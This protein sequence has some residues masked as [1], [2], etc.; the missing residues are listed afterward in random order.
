VLVFA[1]TEQTEI[2]DVYEV[3]VSN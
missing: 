1:R 2:T 3:N